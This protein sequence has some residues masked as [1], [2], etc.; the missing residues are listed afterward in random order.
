MWSFFYMDL[1][2]KNP[3][4]EPKEL[5]TKAFKALNKGDKPF[6]TFIR[7]FT[8]KI[9]EDLENQ[10][11]GTKEVLASI[12]SFKK[13]EK[14]KLDN[15]IKESKNKILE[16]MKKFIDA[17]ITI[18]QQRLIDSIEKPQKIPKTKKILN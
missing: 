14:K 12:M 5:L 7:A 4:I 9:I 2:L 11:E 16:E 1:R 10:F 17:E 13:G 8:S 6:R 15:Q 18:K 3:T